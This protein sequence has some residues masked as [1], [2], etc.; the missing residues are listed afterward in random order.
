MSEERLSRLDA[1]YRF[2]FAGVDKKQKAAVWGEIASFIFEFMGQPTRVL[3]P[4]CGDMEFLRTLP[5]WV[6]KWGVD[7]GAPQGIK[8]QNLKLERGNIF[9]VELPQHYFD[10]IFVSNFLE[11]LPDPDTVGQFLTKMRSGLR[12]G[13]Q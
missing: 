12:G 8:G 10:G 6:E 11:H 13:G 4:A 1:I 2:R 5:D 9:D 3:D 7:L